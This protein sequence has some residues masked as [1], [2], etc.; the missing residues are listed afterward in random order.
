MKHWTWKR[1]AWLLCGLLLTLPVAQAKKQQDEDS[2]RQR[3]ERVAPQRGH[4]QQNTAPRDTRNGN[5]QRDQQDNG[6]RY[7]PQDD[8][9][10]APQPRYDN[11]YDNRGYDRGYAPA[12]RYESAPRY[13]PRGMNLSEAVA[14]AERRTGGRVLSAEPIDDGGQLFYR[15]KV[16]TPNGRVKVLF[17]D[18]Q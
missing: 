18:A 17:L 2:E 12:P 8:R 1:Q 13:A 16:L 9:R 10:Y 14:E 7:A 4:L 5:Q 11:G 3:T 6:R 15:V